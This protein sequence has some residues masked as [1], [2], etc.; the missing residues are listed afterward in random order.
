MLF[1]FLFLVFSPHGQTFYRPDHMFSR[2][3]C[4]ADAVETSV[5]T[6]LSEHDLLK[7]CEYTHGETAD[8]S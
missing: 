4:P 5:Q 2:L 3:D 1:L 8:S 6:P 7:P